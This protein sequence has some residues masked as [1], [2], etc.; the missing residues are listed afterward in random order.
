MNFPDDIWNHII[1]FVNDLNHVNQHKTYM[2]KTLD[3]MIEQK[4][5]ERWY[6][7]EY[8]FEEYYQNYE[9]WRLNDIYFDPDRT[10][11]VVQ[12]LYNYYDE[13]KDILLRVYRRY[14]E[15]ICCQYCKSKKLSI[16][17]MSHDP[18]CTQ[19]FGNKQWKYYDVVN[20]SDDCYRCLEI[21]NKFYDLE[22]RNLWKKSW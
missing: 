21:C 8:L 2:R 16:E 15:C 22:F 18:Y 12:E 4:S 6:D 11:E 5:H 13:H 20:H 14:S 10:E 7:I 1:G 17:S 19:Y 3:E 9:E